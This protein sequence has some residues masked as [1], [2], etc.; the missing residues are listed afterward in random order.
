MLGLTIWTLIPCSWLSIAAKDWRK[1]SMAG[2]EARPQLISMRIFTFL[3]YAAALMVSSMR[4]QYLSNKTPPSEQKQK[5]GKQKWLSVQGSGSPPGFL[6]RH[7]G[8]VIHDGNV[9]EVPGLRND[10][11]NSL[12]VHSPGHRTE[13]RGGS[14]LVW[15]QQNSFLTN[16][17]IFIWPIKL[18]KIFR[19]EST[20]E[21]CPVKREKLTVR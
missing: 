9:N 4:D 7:G 8:G 10:G 15:R 21:R 13:R 11:E 14:L 5:G 16:F 20:E 1:G 17:L 18:M 19:S 2:S 12:Q 3:S 6:K